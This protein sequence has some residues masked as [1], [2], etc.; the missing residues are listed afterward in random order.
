MKISTGS[1]VIDS[2]LEGGLEGD[3][4]TTI[5]GPGASGKTNICLIAAAE[6]ASKGKKVI[7]VNTEEVSIERLKQ[8]SKNAP[9]ENI[10]FIKPKSF[11]LQNQVLD[12][13]RKEIDQ[14]VGMVVVDSIGRL[15]R[16]NIAQEK[17]VSKLNKYFGMQI[18]YLAEIAKKKRIPV[19]LSNQVYDDFE[20]K[21]KIKMVGGEI[22]KSRSGCIIE[23][24]ANGKRRTAIIRKHRAI[25]EGKEV[26]FEIVSE[27]IKEIKKGFDLF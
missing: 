14:K 2:L 13:I 16:I 1:E 7:Y 19:I 10:V 17:D 8:V 27:G 24:K 4:I 26:S 6:T 15:Y 20:E 22:I 12:K 11:W 3:E 21:D 25:K 18:A 5:Y 9:L 23:L